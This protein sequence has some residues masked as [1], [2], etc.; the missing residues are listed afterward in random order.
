MKKFLLIPLAAGMLNASCSTQIVNA[1]KPLAD[2]SLQTGKTYTFVLRNGEKK[3]FRI[4][5]QDGASINGKDIDDK[6][7]HI[8]KSDIAQVR[9]PNPLGTAGIIAGGVAA[10]VLIPA[11][12]SNKPISQQS[13]ANHLFNRV[14][15]H[16]CFDRCQ[17]VDIDFRQFFADVLQHRIVQLKERQLQIFFGNALDLFA[18]ILAP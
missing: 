13:T 12:I 16:Q 10:A 17:G 18:T 5:S 15:L 3:K 6:V 11:Y 9:K 7:Y 14:Q 8:N 1:E 2:A 4:V